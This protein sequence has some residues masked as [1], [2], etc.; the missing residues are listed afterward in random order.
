M[1]LTRVTVMLDGSPRSFIDISNIN[2]RLR[3][4]V[5]VACTRVISAL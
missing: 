3:V 1:A 2:A 5:V 4:Y